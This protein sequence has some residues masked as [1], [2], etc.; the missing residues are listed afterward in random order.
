M[1]ALRVLAQLLCV[2]GAVLATSGCFPDPGTP[3]DAKVINDSESR[4]IVYVCV[5]DPCITGALVL[6]LD[7]G[8]SDTVNG[9]FDYAV[10]YGIA[11]A[12]YHR[13]SCF[14]TAMGEGASKVYKISNGTRCP[15]ASSDLVQFR[16]P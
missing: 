16:N 9:N 15:S 4:R 11:D 6:Q 5:D 7:P 13:I 2:A 12:N 10:D 14:H 1:G 3:F 8:A